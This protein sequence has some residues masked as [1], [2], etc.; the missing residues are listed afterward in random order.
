MSRWRRTEV[1]KLRRVRGRDAPATAGRMPA[2][3][4][5]HT[6]RAYSARAFELRVF[7]PVVLRHYYFP[8]SSYYFRATLMA[9]MCLVRVKARCY[10]ADRAYVPPLGSVNW[11]IRL[12]VVYE[13]DAPVL[14]GNWLCG[15]PLDFSASASH[16]PRH[17]VS[18]S[19]PFVDICRGL[20]ARTRCASI[21]SNAR[22]A[23]LSLLLPLRLP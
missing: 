14:C 11:P 13:D 1:G 19:G 7:F 4:G 16:G 20:G 23:L 21:S 2:Q 3:P 10:C 5:M 17:T 6:L 15:G 22:P 9:P 8:H 12:G 18:I